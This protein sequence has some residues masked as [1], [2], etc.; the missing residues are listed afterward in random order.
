[1]THTCRFAS[2]TLLLLVGCEGSV[3][4]P[5]ADGGD[6]L[7]RDAGPRNSTGADEEDEQPSAEQPYDAGTADDSDV[8]DAPDAGSSA[9]GIG[10]E[11]EDAAPPGPDALAAC[12]RTIAVANRGQLEAALDHAKAGDCLELKDGEHTFPRISA[13]GTAER[14][15]VIRAKN[16]LKARVRSGNLELSGARYL[17]VEGLT[18]ESAG[19]IKLDN[20][21]HCRISRVRIKRK[22]TDQEVD[23]VTVSGASDHA[24]I[25]HC[26]FGPQNRIGNMVMLAGKGSQVV[27]H[28]R[29]DHNYFHDVNYSG[30][31]GWET[32]R[33]GL[34]GYTFSSGHTIIEHNLFVRADSDPE[35]IS[36]KSSDNVIRHNTMRETAGQFTLRHGNRNELYGNYI[37]GDGVEGSA[38]IRVYGGEH[39][40]YNNY[41]ADVE[42]LAIHVD[43]GESDD[44]SGKLTDHKVSYGVE[45]LFNTVVSRR[46]IAVGSGKPLKP[47]DCVIANNLL[48]GGGN[49]LSST[50]GVANTKFKANIVHGSA[51]QSA[52]VLRVDPRLE[53][54]GEIMRIEAASPA[55][56]KAQNDYPSVSEDI[57]GRT[58]VKP[59]IGAHEV[60]MEAATYGL[61]SEDDVG[62]LAP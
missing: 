5:I 3:L 16:L 61:L 34:S 55:V 42:G 56:D 20:C 40:I 62:P 50:N 14:P 35:T 6:E 59:D 2:L 18:F 39:R 37:L 19:N 45:V 53:P 11:G 49:L 46:G 52:G 26:E 54:D 47:R 12:T 31:N 43:G 7:T 8:D 58:R 10:D 13:K 51:S 33:A 17:T 29:I 48:E 27:Q 44:H 36:V 38:G 23:W 1:M 25:D 9:D 57:E 32:I 41:I 22:E 28:T 21:S 24:R 15:I 60:S 30:G 4:P